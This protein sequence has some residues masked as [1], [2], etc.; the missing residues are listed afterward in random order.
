[1]QNYGCSF[2][3]AGE[4]SVAGSPEWRDICPKREPQPE[5]GKVTNINDLTPIEIESTLDRI[6]FDVRRKWENQR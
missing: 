1:M 5:L 2:C 6:R 3:P 4:E